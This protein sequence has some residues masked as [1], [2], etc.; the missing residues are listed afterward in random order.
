MIM[1]HAAAR[2]EMIIIVM[3]VRS[4]RS[5]LRV[6]GVGNIMICKRGNAGSL[7]TGVLIETISTRIW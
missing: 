7:M 3:R 5:S 1:C 4:S 6:Q 2:V